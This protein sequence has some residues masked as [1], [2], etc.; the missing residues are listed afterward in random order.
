MKSACLTLFTDRKLS[1]VFMSLL[2][3]LKWGV[4]GRGYKH[5]APDGA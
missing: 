5:G 1:S 3:E 2:T 4:G